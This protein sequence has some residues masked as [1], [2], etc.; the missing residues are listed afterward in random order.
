MC[1]GAYLHLGTLENNF[2]INITGH[3]REALLR[4]T[5]N[6]CLASQFL[7]SLVIGEN[8]VLGPRHHFVTSM[9]KT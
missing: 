9:A 7:L 4:T 5:Y 8:S 3:L 6:G 2:L 1:W